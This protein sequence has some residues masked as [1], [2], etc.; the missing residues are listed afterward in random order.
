MQASILIHK[1]IL[2]S[3]LDFPASITSVCLSFLFLLLFLFLHKGHLFS[4][5]VHRPSPTSSYFIWC[6]SEVLVDMATEDTGPSLVYLQSFCCCKHLHRCTTIPQTTPS[7][8]H[9]GVNE[10]LEK[11]RY[12]FLPVVYTEVVTALNISILPLLT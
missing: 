1:L 6:D 9:T 2:L 10:F 5:C 12:Q 11:K 7:Q 4:V 3:S 8:K